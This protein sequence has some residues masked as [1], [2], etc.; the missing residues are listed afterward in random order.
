MQI[1]K[2]IKSFLFVAIQFVCLFLIA[3]TGPLFPANWTLLSVELA[4]VTLG[5]WAI[6]AMRVGNFNITPDP[7]SWT[8]LVTAG[9]YR[10]IRHPM[11]LALLITTL[12]L[13][14]NHLTLTRLAVWLLLLLDLALKLAY[15][16][17]ILQKRLV[18]Y[19][20]YA[21]QSYRLV[22]FLY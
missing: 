13:I 18:G 11:Y 9:P 12:P 2:I 19:E 22:P 16:E 15:E 5:V 8:V 14:I 4:G 7:L 21:K 20:Q 6:L 17:R 1:P 3:M 10:L